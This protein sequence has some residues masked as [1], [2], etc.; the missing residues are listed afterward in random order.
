MEMEAAGPVDEL[1][2]VSRGVCDYADLHKNK[3]WPSY[4][5][6]GGRVCSRTLACH[7]GPRDRGGIK[8]TGGSTGD[9]KKHDPA[10]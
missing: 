6:H 8:G 10:S 1:H 3:R 9:S 2:C 5:T 7:S 4:A